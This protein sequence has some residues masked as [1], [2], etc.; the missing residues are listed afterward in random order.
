MVI[1]R[2]NSMFKNLEEMMNGKKVSG[3]DV[4]STE[5]INEEFIEEIE[6]NEDSLDISEGKTEE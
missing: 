1:D 2:T 6:L 3:F 5:V 4:D